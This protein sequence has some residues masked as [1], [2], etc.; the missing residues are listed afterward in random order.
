[1]DNH[2]LFRKAVKDAAEKFK[3][4]PQD[5]VIRLISH[6]D[7]DG[8][9]ASA[10]LSALLEMEGRK[11]HLSNVQHLTIEMLEELALQ[12]YEFYFFSDLGSSH[13]GTIKKLFGNK[14]VFIL[15][16]H[17]LSDKI[18]EDNI[19]Q[20][21]PLMFGIQGDFEISG[22]GICYLFAK[23]VNEKIKFFSHL[24]LL[25]AMADQQEN[26][27]FFGFN[28][29]ILTDAV[30]AGTIEVAQGLRI[31]GAST[32]PIHKVLESNFDFF[33]P[34]ITG[35]ESAALDF[36]KEIG[37]NPK[38]GDNEWKRFY[39][40]TEKDTK[41]LIDAVIEKKKESVP[42]DTIL[43][44][45][46][47]VK[48]EPYDSL[49]RDA[50]EFSTIVNSAGRLGFPGIGV[51]VCL[52]DEECRK[53]AVKILHDYQYSLITSLDWLERNR[54]NDRFFQREGY[55]II[56]GR[57]DI[58][59]SIIGTICTILSKSERVRPETIVIGMSRKSDGRT[60][61]SLRYSSDK[62][63]FDLRDLSKNLLEGFIHSEFGG[64]KNAAGGIFNTEDEKKFLQHAEEI[65]DK[66]ETSSPN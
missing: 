9:T 63:P 3:H 34:G 4:I 57:E 47:T 31:F 23:A 53:K 51:G 25:G 20:L 13:L 58:G 37:I 60:K 49:F 46:Y 59:P 62:N 35:S 50:R 52:G 10:V 45:V 6:F 12:S 21:N 11:Y 42:P 64:H 61:F 27:G 24:P 43:G 41:K 14:T 16:H 8:I 15:D 48:S 1:M 32:K 18:E 33:M 56:D 19:I 30:N 29:E 40:L 36:L 66:M 7:T 26:N 22:A 44:N 65:L 55:A 5:K 39:Q 28:S 2:D 38:N 17:I 54:G